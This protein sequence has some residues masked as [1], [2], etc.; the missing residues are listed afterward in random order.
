LYHRHYL[1]SG[2]KTKGLLELFGEWILS[3]VERQN[4]FEQFHLMREMAALWDLG[5]FLDWVQASKLEGALSVRA[6]ESIVVFLE[7]KN[8]LKSAPLTTRAP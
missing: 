6:R 8:V 3:D 1:R 5:E 7:Q 4:I 2:G